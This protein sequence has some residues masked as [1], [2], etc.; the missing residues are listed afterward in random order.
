MK[1]K[2]IPNNCNEC[3]YT[4]SCMSYYGGLGCNFN[5]EIADRYVQVNTEK[6]YDK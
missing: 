4:K 1:N 3:E 6:T 5:K 2:N